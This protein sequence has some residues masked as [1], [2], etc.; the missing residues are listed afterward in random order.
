MLRRKPTRLEIEEADIDELDKI[1]R[2]LREK[3]EAQAA[4][5]NPLATAVV[6]KTTRDKA[7]EGASA[8]DRMGVSRRVPPQ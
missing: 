6:E 8:Q 5:S 7:I 2:Q 3:A 4:Q 1:R